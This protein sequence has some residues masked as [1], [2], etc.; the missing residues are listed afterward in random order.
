MKSKIILFIHCSALLTN[1][2]ISSAEQSLNRAQILEP[3]TT[4]KPEPDSNSNAVIQYV[5]AYH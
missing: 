2:M 1:V 5:Y 3:E 4:R